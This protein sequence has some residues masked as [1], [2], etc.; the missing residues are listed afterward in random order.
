MSGD[1]RPLWNV[2]LQMLHLVTLVS[3]FSR[4]C[5]PSVGHYSNHQ[6]ILSGAELFQWVF[7][8]KQIMLIKLLVD[9]F[10]KEGSLKWVKQNAF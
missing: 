5:H 8:V 1:S 4:K 3:G 6:K 2:G 7:S 10:H 9:I